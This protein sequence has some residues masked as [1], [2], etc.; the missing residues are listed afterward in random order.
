MNKRCVFCIANSAI[1]LMLG[2]FIYITAG[3][4][5][6][7]TDLIARFHVQIPHIAYPVLIRS[8]ICDFLWGYALLSALVLVAGAHG[9]TGTIKA[10][11][12]AA[13]LAVIMETLQAVPSF[14][15]TFDPWDIVAE[16]AAIVICSAIIQIFLRRQQHEETKDH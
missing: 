6:Y 4:G 8:Y 9:I 3:Q 15:G 11:I 16:F 1:P 5:I 7:L 2:S 10:M 13:I 14:P 12:L